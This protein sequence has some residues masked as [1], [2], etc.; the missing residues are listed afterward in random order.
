MILTYT[1]L[2]PSRFYCLAEQFWWIFGVCKFGAVRSGHFHSK[3]WDEQ[4]SPSCKWPTITVYCPWL[5]YHESPALLF[6]HAVK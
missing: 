5:Q 3:I 4:W 1:F 2:V 6:W